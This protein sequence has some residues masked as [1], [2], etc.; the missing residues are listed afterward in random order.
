[1]TKADVVVGVDVGGTKIA[2]GAVTRAGEILRSERY[3]MDR[4]TQHTS[5]ASIQA[6]LDGF[7]AEWSAPAPLAL[8][9]GVV[10]RTDPAAGVW[11]RA[12]NIPISAPVD[13]TARFGARYGL[14][15]AVD[16]D[17]HAATLAEL[18]WGAGR[19]A[20]DFV[21]LNVGTGT[22]AGLVTNGRLVRGAGNHAGEFGHSF[23]GIAPDVACPCGRRGCL[24]PVASGGGLIERAR[25][26]LPAYPRS[27]LAAADAAAQL[28]AH[29]IFVHADA[30]D[31]LAVRLA[32]DMVSALG[33]ALANLVNLL[34]PQTIVVGGGVWADG[35]LLPRVWHIVQTT[36]LAGAL[37]DL[38]GMVPSSLNPDHVG[39]LG[40]AT[41]AWDLVNERQ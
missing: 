26:L 24:E 34:D 31:P 10:G 1:M 33:I 4:S 30:G 8:G 16:N 14:R 19:N 13:M 22:A 37:S 9:F 38:Q 3:P 5:L 18:Y 41:L 27:P 32:N 7:M 20:D 2:V 15:A 29:T 40:A 39:L 21:Y 28:N 25:E 11:V 35:W 17:V 6:A 12:M 36:A 23:T